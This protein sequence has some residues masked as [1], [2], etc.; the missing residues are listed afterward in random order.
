VRLRPGG[1][2]RRRRRYGASDWPILRLDTP[3]A[4]HRCGA[5]QSPVHD[6]QFRRFRSEIWLQRNPQYRYR[7]MSEGGG[8]HL[9]GIGSPGADWL[10]KPALAK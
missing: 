4:G 8:R 5:G 2:I 1:N 9:E 3:P 10:F 6:V 7:V